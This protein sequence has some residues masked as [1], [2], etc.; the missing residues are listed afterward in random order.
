MSRKIDNLEDSIDE[1]LFTFAEY[2][3]AEAERIGYSNYSYWRSTFQVFKKNK[4]AMLFLTIMII[5]ITFTVVQPYLPNQKSPTKIYI[6]P[7]TNMQL[8]NHPPS[9]E[10]WFGTNSIGQDLWSRIWSGTRT[11]LFIGLLVA[12]WDALIGITV[13]ALWGYVRRLEALIT[14]IYNV[15][16]NI[17][18]TIIQVLFAYILRPSIQTLVIAM[19]ITGWLG[20]ARFIR[21]QIVIIRDREYNLASRCLGTPTMR[22]ITRNLLPYLVSVIMLR[23]SLAIPAAIGSEVFLTYIGLGLPVSIPSLGNLVNEGR[24]VMM[25]PSLRYQLIFPAIVL[26]L[27]TISFYVIGNAF[28]DAADPKTHV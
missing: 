18:T 10:F 2:D 26:S 3:E 21:N 24:L 19:C 28:A 23:M 25:V 16:D 27:I 7:A 6:D 12:I 11:S 5:L 1:S 8:R 22:I 9:R 17:P 14:E 20:T 15:L 4:T 13:G